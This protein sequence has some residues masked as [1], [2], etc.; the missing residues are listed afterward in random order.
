MQL[1]DVEAAIERLGMAQDVLMWPAELFGMLRLGQAQFVRRLR[2]IVD[3]LSHPFTPQLQRALR[4]MRRG[5]SVVIV[6]HNG[7]HYLTLMYHQGQWQLLDAQRTGTLNVYQPFMEA[8]T[9]FFASYA[10]DTMDATVGYGFSDN[11][12]A[13]IH[14]FDS[15][16]SAMQVETNA[17]AW[18]DL[19]EE[20][21]STTTS[22][23]TGHSTYQVNSSWESTVPALDIDISIEGQEGTAQPEVPSET[24]GDER[25]RRVSGNRSRVSSSNILS[26]SRDRRR[27]TRNAIYDI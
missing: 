11:A 17:N 3:D 10:L 5:D 2:E 15:A 14:D 6:L 12:V 19:T 26:S 16:S 18:L 23:S 1:D 4:R 21:E 8:L 25:S 22:S 24:S 13:A 9:Q 20:P 27:S 7:G